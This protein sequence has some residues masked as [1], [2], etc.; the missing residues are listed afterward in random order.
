MRHNTITGLMLSVVLV[1]GLWAAPS[2]LADEKPRRGGTLNAALAGDPPS[3]DMHQEQTFAVAQP[4]GPIYNNLIV[5]DPHNYPQ[6]I[7]DLAKSWS[8]SADYLT[9]TFTLHEGVTFHDGS[10]LTSAD[11]KARWDKIVFPPEGVVSPRKSEY[12]FIKSIEAP[13]PY[14]VVFRLHYPAASFLG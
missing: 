6:I 5:F 4:L 11:V 14:T 3:L 2:A 9:Y 7:G 13:D 8:V 1:I 10:P 12:E